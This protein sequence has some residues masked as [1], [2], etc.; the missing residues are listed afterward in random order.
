LKEKSRHDI[1]DLLDAPECDRGVVL[2]A[3]SLG[4]EGRKALM[5]VVSKHQG[6]GGGERA[7]AVHL[8]GELGCADLTKKAPELLRDQVPAV[9]HALIHALSRISLEDAQTLLLD[10]LKDSKTEP[11]D[12]L[13]VLR[14][15]ALNADE[16]LMDQLVQWADS[17]EEDQLRAAATDALALFLSTQ[18]PEP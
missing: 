11:I 16:A 5:A 10:A 15:L 7:R 13:H 3:A 14:A 9:R 18:A 17:L 4:A 6:A 8:L 12:R 2:A 1:L